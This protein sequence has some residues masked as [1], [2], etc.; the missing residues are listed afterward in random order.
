M[1]NVNTAATIFT[2][3][4]SIRVVMLPGGNG[5]VISFVS[6]TEGEFPR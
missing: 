4:D 1:G 6:D 3:K 5:E 2:Q